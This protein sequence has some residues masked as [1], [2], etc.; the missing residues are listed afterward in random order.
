MKFSILL[1]LILLIS[2]SQPPDPQNIVDLA[3]AQSGTDGLDNAKVEFEFR[4]KEYGLEQNNGSFEMV[5][6]WKDSIGLIRDE[7][8]NSGF[9]RQIN[10]SLNDVADSMAT[11]YTNSINSVIYFALLPYRLNDAAVIKEYLGEEKIEGSTYHKIKITFNEEGGGEDHDDEFIY[12][13][14]QSTHLIAYLAYSYHTVG[15]GMRFRKA[16]NPRI[17]NGVR[18]VDYINYKPKI[19]VNLE[20]IGKAFTNQELIELSRIKLENVKVE[21]R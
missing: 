15:G 4:G 3:L 1:P 5:R 16:I 20:E 2:C 17:I 6:L 10:G 9:K 21:L 18:I 7:V 19:E 8:S 13:F 11:K 14:D 12:W